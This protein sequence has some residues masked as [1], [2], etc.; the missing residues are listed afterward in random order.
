MQTKARADYSQSMKNPNHTDDPTNIPTCNNQSQ[1]PNIAK[2]N[3][4]VQGNRHHQSG[5]GYFLQVFFW[6]PCPAT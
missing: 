2:E 3:T 5:P 6:V 1:T 4:W